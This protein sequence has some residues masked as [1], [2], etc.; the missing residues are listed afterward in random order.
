MVCPP[1]GGAVC[2]SLAHA[3]DLAF[4]PGSSE[5]AVGF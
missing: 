5:V 1:L 2:N 4:A 3:L